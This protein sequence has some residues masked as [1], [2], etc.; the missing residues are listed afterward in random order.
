MP[1]SQPNVNRPQPILDEQ[2]FQGLLAAAFTIQEHNDRRNNDRRNHDHRNNDRRNNDQPG[3]PEPSPPLLSVC[4]HCGALKTADSSH[5]EGC[6]LEEFRLGERLQRNWASIWLLSQEQG[7]LPD[8]ESDP[9]NSDR[10]KPPRNPTRHAATEQV[11]TRFEQ[12]LP[13]ERQ[14]QAEPAF[15][16]SNHL[17][18]PVAKKAAS[19]MRMIGAAKT[20]ES[21]PLDEVEVIQAPETG[22]KANRIESEPAEEELLLPGTGFE[23][24]D[25]VGVDPATDS[26]RDAAASDPASLLQRLA[27]LRITLRFHRA[28]LYLGLAIVTAAF[29]LLWP[30]ATVPTRRPTLGV[31]ERALIKLGVAEPPVHALHFQGDPS[32]QV[33]LDTHSALY[34]CPGEDQYG[35]TADGRFTTQREAQIDRFDPANRSACE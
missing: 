29:A 7:L 6:G 11:P 27:D 26:S 20:R 10:G 5:C 22:T 23:T 16:A 9:A 32:V 35:K 4:E 30:A 14:A 15:A 21:L 19:D 24:S 28:N 34:Y 1:L 18:R 3:D 33:W 31:W 17:A 12:P 13:P 2:S 8:R 25:E